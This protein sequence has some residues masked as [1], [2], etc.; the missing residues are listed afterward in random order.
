MF[1]I[2]DGPFYFIFFFFWRGGGVNQKNLHR[3]IRQ[4]R[5]YLPISRAI[6]S[7]ILTSICQIK[8]K[9]GGSAYSREFERNFFFLRCQ[10]QGKCHANS[11]IGL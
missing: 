3:K 1:T 4:Y 5:S 11:E 10:N 9:Q 6:F 2:R 8:S 7:E